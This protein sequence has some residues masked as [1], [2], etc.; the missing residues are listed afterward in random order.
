MY[1]YVFRGDDVGQK[2]YD[3]NYTN[4][5]NYDHV[6]RYLK[7]VKEEDTLARLDNYEEEIA[8]FNQDLFDLINDCDED[9][10]EFM[11]LA[12][13]IVQ[14]DVLKEHEVYL[15]KGLQRAQTSRQNVMLTSSS[16]SDGQRSDQTQLQEY[17]DLIDLYTIS[18]VVVRE[19]ANNLRRDAYI[20]AGYN[21]LDINA[22]NSDQGDVRGTL[23]KR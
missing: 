16:S 4:R 10:P 19:M 18:I 2:K 5:I 6:R 21:D 13:L 15:Q 12:R 14:H 23:R 9:A 20:T 22:P 17:Q 3:P 8:T 1:T 7:A 11:A